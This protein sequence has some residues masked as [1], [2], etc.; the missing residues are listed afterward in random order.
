MSVIK[1]ELKKEHIILLKN[2]RW[3]LMENKFIV[4][5]EDI[6]EDPA[7]FGADTIYEGI[8]LVLNGKPESFDPM[9]STEPK[10]YTTEQ[11][12]EW[13]KLISELPTALDIILY[14]GTF[15]LGTYR[16]KYHIRDWK[17]VK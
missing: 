16:T 14:N 9:N 10:T 8:D 12:A 5:T 13:D 6:T 17:K 2:L 11:I 15:E 3:G 1:F 4:S 7:P